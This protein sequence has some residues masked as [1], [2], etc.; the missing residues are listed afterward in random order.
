MEAL[1]GI[2]TI[3]EIGQ[4]SGEHP[5]RVGRRKKAIQGLA[6]M[7]FECKRGPQ[8]MAA[9]QEPER[10]YS[11]IGKTNREGIAIGMD[12]RARALDNIFVERL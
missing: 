12:G 4:E 9:H 5:V 7:L 8:P 10:L 3:N 6:K 1:R 2:E 11:E